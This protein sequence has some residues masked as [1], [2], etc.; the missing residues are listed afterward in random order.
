MRC[1]PSACHPRPTR[2]RV[3]ARQSA[4][5]RALVACS[6]RATVRRWRGAGARDGAP[7]RSRLAIHLILALAYGVVEEGIATMSLF[8]PNYVGLRLLDNGYIP[9]L[10]IGLPWTVH[11][12]TLH[13]VW[14]VSVPILTMKALVPT[15]RTAPWLGRL[16]LALTGL[17]FLLGLAAMTAL[18][19]AQSRADEAEEA[20]N[21]AETI[22]EGFHR[23][24]TNVHLYSAGT[25]RPAWAD[26][27]IE[28]DG[29]TWRKFESHSANPVVLLDSDNRQ[30]A[31]L[32]PTG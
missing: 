30:T 22:L 5:H 18:S 26:A 14:S 24:P 10:R 28:R 6:P 8:N 3:P 23:R 27:F 29:R 19:I 15:R 17:L 25:W 4:D 32:R 31:I 21:W 20:W 12:L 9:Q 13:V 1:R 2:R 16:G 7:H 11:V